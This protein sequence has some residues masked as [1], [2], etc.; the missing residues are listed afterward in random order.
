M[1]QAEKYLEYADNCAQLAESATDKPS[2][3][4]YRRMANA[5][6]ALAEEQRWLDGEV[7]PVP[8]F[9]NGRRQPSAHKEK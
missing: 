8:R 7:P 3:V 2:R 4:R 1:N 9:T 5:W 6:R